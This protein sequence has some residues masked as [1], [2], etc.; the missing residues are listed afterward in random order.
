M[1]WSISYISKKKNIDFLL[2]FTQ[3]NNKKEEAKK[4]IQI[5]ERIIDVIKLI[6]KRGLSYQSHRNESTLSL[7]DPVA[8]HGNFLDIIL[9]LKKY[10]IVLSEHIDKT[11]KCAQVK[12]ACHKSTTVQG[13][14]SLITFLSKTTI[15]V[16]ID[17]INMLMKKSIVMEVQAAG[18]FSI[19]IDT[20]Q[21]IS[22][23]DQCSIIIWYVNMIGVNEK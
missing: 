8:D 16:I 11:V 20:T 23:Q 9:L 6:G 1:F 5:I 7:L 22:V 2:F 14:G 3:K 15:N 17:I 12:Y 18:M 10:D 19:Q 4:N 13:R 21:D